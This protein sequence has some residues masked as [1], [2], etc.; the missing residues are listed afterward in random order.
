M[1]IEEYKQV[2]TGL[3][4]KIFQLDGALLEM[5]KQRKRVCEHRKKFRISLKRLQKLENN[6]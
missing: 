4:A 2:I 1:T 3:S 6:L 5:E